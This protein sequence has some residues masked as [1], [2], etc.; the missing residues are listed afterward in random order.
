[1]FLSSATIGTWPSFWFIPSSEAEPPHYFLIVYT[2]RH[3]QM[4]SAHWFESHYMVVQCTV[5]YKHVVQNIYL[6]NSRCLLSD[7]KNVFH[8]F[9]Y[10]F[11]VLWLP[12]TTREFVLFSWTTPQQVSISRTIKFLKNIRSP[13]P[14]PQKMFFDNF[15][16]CF[17]PVK[18]I[19]G[20]C[21]SV[22]GP[23]PSWVFVWGSLAIL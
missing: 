20:R 1:M 22:W 14:S 12:L 11:R 19:C 6:Y 13:Y 8:L 21:L 23:L 17:R 7:W 9:L 18:G 4:A 10:F 2:Q 16:E 15:E 3:L 5:L